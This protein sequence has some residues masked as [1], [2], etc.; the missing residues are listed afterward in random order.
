MLEP[1]R[2]NSFLVLGRAGMD[3]YADPPGAQAQHAEKF[4]ASLGG[5]AGNTAAGIAKLGGHAAL[6]SA[7]SED[8]VGRFTLN[9]LGKYGVTT[10]HVRQ[11]GGEL[12]TSLAVVETRLEDFQSV[13]YRNNAADFAIVEPQI[14]QID[15]SRFGGLIVS[16]TA[17]AAEPSCQSTLMAIEKAGNAGLTTILD[18]DYRPYSWPSAAA[19]TAVC[20]K[21]ASLCSV[22]VGNDEEFDVLAG[23]IGEGEAFARQ[24]VESSA[25]VAIYKRGQHGSRTYTSDGAFDVGVFA[26]KA[27]KPVGAGDAFMAALVTSIAN[28]RSLEDAVVRGSAAASITVSG[29][30]CAPAMPTE[31]VLS[32]FIA[33]HPSPARPERIEHAHTAV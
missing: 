6:V 24:A 29:I 7:V 9:E 14:E 22:L 8:S 12:R 3:L 21:A 1:L 11:V 5:S 25:Q 18:V 15:W 32:D 30:G 4:F 10:D 33:T 2:K 27:L 26:T 19:A 28:G 13:I 20:G 16:G 31:D 17:L 23:S